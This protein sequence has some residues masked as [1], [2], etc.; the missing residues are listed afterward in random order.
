MAVG[1]KTVCDSYIFTAV[2][3]FLDIIHNPVLYKNEMKDNVQKVN[4]CNHIPWS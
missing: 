3:D 1:S 2:I 4:N